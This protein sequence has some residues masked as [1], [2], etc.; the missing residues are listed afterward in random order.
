VIQIQGQQRATGEL[1]AIVLVEA[2]DG[3]RQGL[4]AGDPTLVAVIDLTG[5]DVQAVEAGQLPFWLFT[6]PVAVML[7][8]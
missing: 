3:G 7:K 5:V 8:T 4:V 6:N 1:S 2:V